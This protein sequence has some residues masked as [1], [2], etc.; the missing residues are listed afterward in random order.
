MHTLTTGRIDTKPPPR[1]GIQ[2]YF[3]RARDDGD[4]HTLRALIADAERHGDTWLAFTMTTRAN[5]LTSSRRRRS[6]C[7]AGTVPTSTRRNQGSVFF[8]PANSPY[9]ELGL[10]KS[11]KI[12]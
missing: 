2:T 3:L 5:P 6:S 10:V 4:E 7:G 9:P 1:P 8:G 12:P 11:A